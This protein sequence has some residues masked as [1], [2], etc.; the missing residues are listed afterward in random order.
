MNGSRHS[1]ERGMPSPRGLANLVR[2]AIGGLI[3]AAG[4][5]LGIEHAFTFAANLIR[6]EPAS[7]LALT[8][9]Q[10][11]LATA[12]TSIGNSR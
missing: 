9:L 7:H 8:R 5:G 12:L 4:A 10:L 1:G 11:S 3:L 2:R 6:T